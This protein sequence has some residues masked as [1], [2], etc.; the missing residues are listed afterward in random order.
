MMKTYRWSPARARA[1]SFIAATLVGGGLMLT[2]SNGIAAETSK[3]VEEQVREALAPVVPAIA[4]LAVPAPP[5]PAAAVAPVAA[6]AAPAKVELALMHPHPAP[7]PPLPPQAAVPPIPPMPPVHINGEE[8]SREIREAMEEARR[9]AA[10]AR[11]E[12]LREAAEERREAL[13]EAQESLREGVRSREQA[14]WAREQGQR[15]REQGQLARQQAQRAREN[16][17]VAVKACPANHKVSVQLDSKRTSV[18]C[19]GW[20]DKE[21]AEVRRS[22]L[23][24]LQSARAS[25]ASMD[26]RHMP[27]HA[28]EQ[29][30]ESIDRQIERLRESN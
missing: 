1:G 2:A 18:R 7:L 30:L 4:P 16:A 14:A 10:E 24:G 25:I 19:F 12:A 21:K 23:S 22:M 29:A 28:R 27:P 15:A 26:A 6:P 3:Q 11:Q 20:T 8:I 9:E 17:R 5:A 13:R